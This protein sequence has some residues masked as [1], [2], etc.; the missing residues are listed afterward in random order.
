MGNRSIRILALL[1]AT[2][3]LSCVASAQTQPSAQPTTQPSKAAVVVLRGTIDDYTRDK[4][5]A[6]FRDARDVGAKV[7]IVHLD[8]PGGLVTAGLEI[9]QFIKQQTDIHTVAMVHK[10]YSAGAMVALACDEITMEPWAAIG[11]CAPILLRDDKTLEPLPETERAKLNSPVLADFR[12]SAK[13]N[14]YSTP[15][16]EA[17][18]TVGH[19]IH[20]IEDGEGTKRLVD[21]PEYDDLIKDG[22]K[23]V[24]GVPDP[25]NK[26]DELFTV[27]TD[28]AKQIGLCKQVAASPEALAEAR[29]Y[30]IAGTFEPG[31][32]E[33][34]I[35]V[36]NSGW[37]RGLLI[38]LFI[39]S[40]QIA[41]SAPG[42][43]AAEAIA[44]LTLGLLIGVPLLTGYAQWWEIVII[45]AGLAL[46]AFEIF[47]FPGH[48]VSA[49]VGAVMVIGGL[50]M[51]FVPKEPGGMP[52]VMP[53]LSGTYQAL[54]RGLITVAAG[55]VCS[56]FLG[57][58]LQRYLPK[59]PYFRRL[60]LTTS[61]GSTPTPDAAPT[62]AW[63]VVGAMGRAATDL[64]PGGKGAF[65]DPAL[66]D[67]RLTQVVS[68][69][70]FV[71][72]GTK[73]I[74]REVAGNRVVVK[75]VV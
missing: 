17:M 34:I 55:L 26:K 74:V 35:E 69:S 71:V 9:S 23:P 12:D 29:G 53:S 39:I 4:L 2:V 75:A 20:Y 3:I 43:G 52:G 63:P 64:R 48:F 36:L 22:W 18:V 31:A 25:I 24:E 72:E 27:H 13:R 30:D 62:S 45:F 14:G 73:L 44:L 33:K 47:V 58:W 49:I 65:H 57:L 38:T 7:V 8:T 40:L 10:A 59:V 50:V 51:T 15:L 19:S 41:I 42:H 5:F 56:L 6:G 11:D 66:G 61:V 70:G 54:E 37:A 28:L 32:G 1:L 21:Q 68:E 16:A 60:I 46:L 67:E